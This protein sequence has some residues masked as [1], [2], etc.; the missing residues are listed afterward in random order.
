VSAGPDSAVVSP[1]PRPVAVAGPAPTPE[2]VASRWRLPFSPWHLILLPTAVL[3][4]LPLI[5]MVLSSFMSNAQI[6]QFPPAIIP[7]SFHLDGWRTVLSDSDF[8]R[9]FGNSVIVSSVTVFSN[10]VFCSLAGYA[11]ARLKFR[12]STALFLLILFTL[13][14]PFQ[15]TMIP[16]FIVMDKLGLVDSLG[17]LIVPELATPF[18]VFLM[19]QFFVNL[20]K[21]VEEAAQIDGCSRLGVLLHVALPLARPALAT[22][23][24]LTFLLIWNDLLWPLIAINSDQNATLPLGLTT[25]QGQHTQDFSAVMAGNVITVTPVLLVFLLAQ[26]TF[27]QSLTSSAVKG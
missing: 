27:I 26:R 4:A 5:W 23:A 7:D 1:Q 6:N 3:F 25:F 17:A 12:G 2:P 22:L 10:L 9:W 18:G 15:L 21:E 24:A 8:P 19:R 14:I 13:V 11:F 20:P 16:T